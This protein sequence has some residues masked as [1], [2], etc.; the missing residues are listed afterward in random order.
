M[1]ISVN[2]NGHFE[3][4]GAWLQILQ[5][6]GILH[7]FPYYLTPMTV[8]GLSSYGSPNLLKD[9]EMWE[10]FESNVPVCTIRLC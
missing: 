8:L 10:K 5:I 4:M 2:Q 1:A 3:E 6:V 7:Y 9:L